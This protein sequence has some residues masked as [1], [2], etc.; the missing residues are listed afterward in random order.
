MLHLW[1]TIYQNM[2]VD[3]HDFYDHRILIVVGRRQQKDFSKRSFAK[4]GNIVHL[5][6]VGRWRE[7][8]MRQNTAFEEQNL[9]IIIKYT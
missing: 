6:R 7:G 5:E 3:R 1:L 9:Y 8:V 4:L 2:A